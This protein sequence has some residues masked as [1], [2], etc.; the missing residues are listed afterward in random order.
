[1]TQKTEAIDPMLDIFE[2]WE[3]RLKQQNEV[4]SAARARFFVVASQ[5]CEDSKR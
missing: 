4:L 5:F 2:E 3:E 1:M